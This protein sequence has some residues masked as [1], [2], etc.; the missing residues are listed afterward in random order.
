MKLS[1]C[2]AIV[3]LLA[4]MPLI[5][6]EPVN[7]TIPVSAAGEIVVSNISGS[8]EIRGWDRNEV[9]ITGTLGE[10]TERLEVE[11][12]G[13]CVRIVVR[14]PRRSRNV[15]ETHLSIA[16]PQ[17]SSVEVETVSAEIAVEAVKGSLEL[18]TVSG[19]LTVGGRPAELA[20]SSVSGRIKIDFA[21][22]D[23][24]IEAV[25]GSVEIFD[26]E[27]TVEV[28]SVAGDLVVH[29]GTLDRLEAG[30][31]SGSIHCEAIPSERGS[32]E[33]ESMSG[34]VVLVVPRSLEADYELSTFS[35]QI[36]NQIGPKPERKSKYAPGVTAEFS[37]GSGAARIS[38][39][40]FSGHVKL[41]VQ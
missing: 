4:A 11:D 18:M 31:T 32:F 35:G 9:K 36:K 40:S 41:L 7:Q 34:N 10:G 15:E 17:R 1:R 39:S 12:D 25:S 23:C 27:G 37:I 28:A 24:E 21:P 2:L 6:G 19:N 16:V 33:F 14:V 22:G 30:T 8:V 3:V 29:G 20:A 13:D 5:A 38:M 26:G